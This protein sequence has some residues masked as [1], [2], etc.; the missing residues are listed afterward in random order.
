MRAIQLLETLFSCG[1]QIGAVDGYDVVAAVGGG[2]KDGL[3]LSHQGEG[4]GRGYTAQGTR[5]GTDV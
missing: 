1:V 5:V 4:Y 2:V 3:V